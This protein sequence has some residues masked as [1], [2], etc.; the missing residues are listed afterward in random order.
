MATC[1][2]KPVDSRS[3]H[4]RTLTTLLL[5]AAVA[6]LAAVAKHFGPPRQAVDW[7]K[8]FERMPDNAP[9]TW[10]FHN[11]RAIRENTDRILELLEREHPGESGTG[12]A[13]T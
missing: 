13:S 5:V 11:I 12:N 1:L 4:H 3:Q 9:P 8:R 6:G 10:M 7:E 2:R